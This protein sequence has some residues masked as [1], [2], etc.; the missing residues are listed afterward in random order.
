M[1]AVGTQGKLHAKEGQ[2]FIDGFTTTRTCAKCSS[3]ASHSLVGVT[4]RALRHRGCK[5]LLGDSLASSTHWSM[6]WSLQLGSSPQVRCTV[7]P[8]VLFHPRQ[9]LPKPDLHLPSVLETTAPLHSSLV[10]WHPRIYLSIWQT[11][12]REVSSSVLLRFW[13]SGPCSKEAFFR[14]GARPSAS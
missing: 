12:C 13:R 5:W 11:S 2:L 14:P 6:D 9:L 7:P 8:P 3:L 10:P 1:A 4:I